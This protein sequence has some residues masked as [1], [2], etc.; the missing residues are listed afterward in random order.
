MHAHILLH[1]V[2]TVSVNSDAALRG[3]PTLRNGSAISPYHVLVTV[4]VAS[5]G[6]PH[7]CLR[8]DRHVP[9][10]KPEP[11]PHSWAASL[12]FAIFPWPR[13]SGLDQRRPSRNSAHLNQDKSSPSLGAG[14]TDSVLRQL[15]RQSRISRRM[16]SHLRAASVFRITHRSVVMTRQGSFPN[17]KDTETHQSHHRGFWVHNNCISATYAIICRVRFLPG[18][19]AVTPG[20]RASPRSERQRVTELRAAHRALPSVSP[21]LPSPCR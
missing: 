19:C 13:L 10:D 15:P 20:A 14:R 18:P 11:P 21:R 1:L 9:A 7:V 17:H 4:M 3:P 16:V 6:P 12:C 2:G 8:V 5:D